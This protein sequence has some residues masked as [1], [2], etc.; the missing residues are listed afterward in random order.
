MEKPH[1]ML[2]SKNSNSSFCS[3]FFFVFIG[4]AIRATKSE[5]IDVMN[6][7][8]CTQDA[9]YARDGRFVNCCKP[10]FELPI[11]IFQLFH[12]FFQYANTN[13]A[14]CVSLRLTTSYFVA[15]KNYIDFDK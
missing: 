10:S 1:E 12:C 3:G 6:F 5:K 14:K 4:P 8:A 11:W 7:Y 13:R 2:S 15:K 9:S